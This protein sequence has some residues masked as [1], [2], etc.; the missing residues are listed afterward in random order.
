L[1]PFQ[2]ADTDDVDDASGE[3]VDTEDSGSDFDVSKTKSNPN[4]NNHSDS[5]KSKKLKKFFNFSR[6]KEKVV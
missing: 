3:L 1:F 5:K 6:K 2:E 4:L